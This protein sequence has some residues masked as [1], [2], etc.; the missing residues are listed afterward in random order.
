MTRVRSRVRSRVVLTRTDL[1]GPVP[2]QCADVPPHTKIAGWYFDS[3]RWM[4]FVPLYMVLPTNPAMVGSGQ[5]KTRPDRVRSW[6]GLIGSGYD[7]TRLGS[8]QVRVKPDLTLPDAIHTKEAPPLC[9]RS[10]GLCLTHC[11]IVSNSTNSFAESISVAAV[12]ALAPGVPPAFY[13]SVRFLFL[14][15]VRFACV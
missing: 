9:C 8:G 1:T 11:H 4:F 5:G 10:A 14:R 13:A 2:S 15:P 6:S 7:L 12:L 3:L